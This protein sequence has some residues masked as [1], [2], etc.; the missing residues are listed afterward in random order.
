MHVHKEGSM[1]YRC[2][3]LTAVYVAE[4]STNL[5]SISAWGR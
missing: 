4:P 1:P 5:V 3:D 2:C